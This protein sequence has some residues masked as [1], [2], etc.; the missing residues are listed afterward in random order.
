MRF[1]ETTVPPVIANGHIHSFAVNEVTQELLYV[2]SSHIA[3]VSLQTLSEVKRIPFSSLVRLDP[4]RT[5]DRKFQEVL[6]QYMNFGLHFLNSLP[7]LNVW[8]GVI[9]KRRIVCISEELEVSNEVTLDSSG[10]VGLQVHPVT[11]DLFMLGMEGKIFVMTCEYSFEGVRKRVASLYDFEIKISVKKQIGTDVN[12]A[13]LIVSYSDSSTYFIAST[14]QTSVSSEIHIWN[15]SSGEKL[16]S[17][18][19]GDSQ[20][21]SIT[22]L[23]AFNTVLALIDST[24]TLVIY[25]YLARTEIVRTGLMG[26]VGNIEALVVEDSELTA[27]IYIFDS[28]GRLYDYV[29][30]LGLDSLYYSVRTRDS[31]TPSQHRPMDKSSMPSSTKLF[32][33]SPIKSLSLIRLV[34]RHTGLR[35][36]WILAEGTIEIINLGSIGRVTGMKDVKKVES[37]GNQLICYGENGS[38]TLMDLETGKYAGKVKDVLMNLTDRDHPSGL[39]VPVFTAYLPEL[40]FMAFV[41]FNGL[42]K[43]YN[44]DTGSVSLNFSI[45]KKTIS[46]NC[47]IPR[48]QSE[49]LFDIVLGTNVG[50]I[51]VLSYI[52]Y[53]KEVLQ[54]RKY[55]AHDLVVFVKY[56]PT[57]QRVITVGREGVVRFLAFP[58][59]SWDGTVFKGFWSDCTA[60]ALCGTSLLVLGYESGML[61]TLYFSFSGSYPSVLLLEYHIFKVTSVSGLPNSASEAVS[62][63][64]AGNIVLWNVDQGQALKVFSVLNHISAVAMAGNVV[65]ERLYAVVN[66]NIVA[67]SLRTKTQYVSFSYKDVKVWKE[68]RVRKRT[69]YK[70]RKIVKK[71]Q[72]RAG[73]MAAL[74]EAVRREGKV[75]VGSV[76]HLVRKVK[77]AERLV[78]RDPLEIKQQL[79]VNDSF[80]KLEAKKLTDNLLRNYQTRPMNHI[81][82]LNSLERLK[83]SITQVIRY[84][85]PS[86]PAELAFTGRGLRRISPLIKRTLPPVK[87]PK[88]WETMESTERIIKTDRSMPMSIARKERETEKA[89]ELA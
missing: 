83:K 72:M 7:H 70:G 77:V 63:D 87:G 38:V 4:I 84:I 53:S 45:Q 33:Q 10:V 9:N 26:F 40:D 43:L 76:D 55:A 37:K 73:S 44:L 74:D 42:L 69:E 60:G 81:L 14:D 71:N 16:P 78:K 27:G 3:L 28:L 1:Q 32:T 17:L 86:I 8:L 54:K 25:D 85:S 13:R 29:P 12:L 57:L 82:E 66:G 46:A 21:I 41:S 64:S 22:S 47:F 68:E 20:P 23:A 11:G 67:L 59:Y 2:T 24:K 36:L 62:G 50:E 31:L 34:L 48:S 39:F 49:S 89:H 51:L 79:R 15:H 19:H 58:E 18:L 75:F 65:C 5:A 52:S 35:Q 30:G 61:Q 56:L 6:Q 80:Y 88:T